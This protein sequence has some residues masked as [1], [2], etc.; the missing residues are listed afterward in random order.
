M[1]HKNILKYIKYNGYNLEEVGKFLD[2][3]SFEFN[4]LYLKGKK[5]FS[6]IHLHKL[7]NL[8]ALEVK[9]LIEYKKPHYKVSNFEKKNIKNLLANDMKMICGFQKI[10]NNYL[11]LNQKVGD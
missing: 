10:L 4:N 6:I 11:I 3:E 8:F 9:D 1:T 5:E 7:A 2:I